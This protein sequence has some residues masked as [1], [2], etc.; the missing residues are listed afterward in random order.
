MM[1]IYKRE[2]KGYYYTTTG[3]L[4]SAIFLSVTGLIF[5]MNNILSRSSDM[6]QLLSMSSYL[7]ML[8]TPLLVM[9]AF[10]S[11]IKTGTDRLLLSA[12][13]SIWQ[14]VLAKY[15]AALTILLTTA[16]LSFL[17]PC[18]LAF[19]GDVYWPEVFVGWIG[20]VFQGAAFLALDFLL[21]AF[22]R[23]AFAAFV[24]ALGANLSIWLLSVFATSSGPYNT[25]KGILKSIDFHTR[26]VPFL[27]GQLSFANSAYYLITV[28]ALLLINICI[29]P[30]K[31]RNLS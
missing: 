8:L 30:S 13:I 3:Y 9:R 28:T 10:S 19:V 7:W 31:R 21:A 12:P 1:A 22:V 18:I 26:L 29:Y 20:L 5:F 2:F 23:S 14:V 24:S 11:D 17:F 27:N 6:V 25:L 15:F 16:L 4:F